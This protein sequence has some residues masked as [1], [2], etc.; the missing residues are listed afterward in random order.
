MVLGVVAS[1]RAGGRTAT[2]VAGVLAGAAASGARTA[3]VELSELDTADVVQ[4]IDDADAVVFGSPVYRATYS[5]QLKSL[6]E[7]VERGKHGETTAPLRGKAAAIVMT[8]ASGHH[9]L[10]TEG[11]HAVLTTFFAVQTL[12]PAL[13]LETSAYTPESGLTPQA[14]ELGRSH[15]SALTEL[16]AAVRGSEALRRLEPLV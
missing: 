1:P 11:L 3:V 7:R 15:G 6:L 8:G 4:R 9:F 5:A 16:A 10:A 12:A 2:A 14:A 13:Y